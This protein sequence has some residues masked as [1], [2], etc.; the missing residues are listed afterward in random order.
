M[1]QIEAFFLVLSDFCTPAW[2]SG[3]RCRG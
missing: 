3:Y 2:A 1:H